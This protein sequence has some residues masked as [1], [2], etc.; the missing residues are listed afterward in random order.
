M[1]EHLQITHK[2]SYENLNDT[3]E[4][5]KKFPVE[6]EEKI[7]KDFESSNSK[8]LLC[9]FHDKK[10]VGGLGFV[11]SFGP[12]LKHS[13]RL[14]M[15]I[16][17]SF[18][19]MGLGTEMLKYSLEMGKLS[20]FHRVE[21]TVRTYNKPGIALYEKMGFKKVGL[22]KDAAFID[23]EYVDEFLYQTLL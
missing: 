19:D 7:L 15:S 12:F 1:L 4:N 2:E 21:L 23:N 8:F 13:A 22:L 20:G 6:D 17:K 11:G 18:C 10:I 3:A 9:A 5:W 14:G 16:Q